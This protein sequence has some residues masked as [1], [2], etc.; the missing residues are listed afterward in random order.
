MGDAAER[1]TPSI[2]VQAEHHT[3]T[4]PSDP[5]KKVY[6]TCMVTVQVPSRVPGARLHE[7]ATVDVVGDSAGFTGS[8]TATSKMQHQLHGHLANNSQSTIL[9]P[10]ERERIA[11]HQAR[12]DGGADPRRESNATTTANTDDFPTSPSVSAISS[13]AKFNGPASLPPRIP[14]PA[15]L[16]MDQSL[17]ASTDNTSFQQ[18]PI[19]HATS[20]FTTPMSKADSTFS[21]FQVGSI[22]GATGPS[23]SAMHARSGSL[24]GEGLNLEG[25]STA[26]RAEKEREREAHGPF[27]EVVLDLTTRMADWKGHQPSNFGSLRMWDSLHVKKD[28]NVREFIVYLF[29]EALLCVVDDRKKESESRSQHA[30]HDRGDTNAI[31][32]DRLRLKGRVFVKHMHRVEEKV[33]LDGGM[34]LTIHMV[35]TGLSQAKKMA[36]HAHF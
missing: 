13:G 16:Q 21:G 1:V 29:E 14:L 10:G 24:A 30:S 8:L 12:N 2:T 23:S 6:L 18:T 5:E 19:S 26:A 31:G 11:Q 34:S 33:S 17:S 27:A 4:R 15:S 32:G 35:R 36:N 9:A 20:A 22:G 3:L 28:R 25:S 7:Q